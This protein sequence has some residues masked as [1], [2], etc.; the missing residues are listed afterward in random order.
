MTSS[1]VPAVTS[2]HLL[3]AARVHL[4]N[5]T[6]FLPQTQTTGSWPAC[7][8]ACL[9]LYAVPQCRW[10]CILPCSPMVST[11]LYSSHVSQCTYLAQ[12]RVLVWPV[13]LTHCLYLGSQV[14][15]SP[16]STGL[17]CDLHGYTA[18]CVVQPGGRVP[19]PGALGRMCC[20]I[21]A[22]FHEW[23]HTYTLAPWPHVAY[24]RCCHVCCV[25]QQGGHST[26]CCLRH[27]GPTSHGS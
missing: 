24:V 27:T 21:V 11:C 22:W 4:R 13:Y 8:Q 14:H 17:Q 16:L 25:P 2:R 10:Y 12:H 1:A 15:N 5:D 23:L 19:A 9:L 26:S 3:L 18:S 20:S 7:M 6:A